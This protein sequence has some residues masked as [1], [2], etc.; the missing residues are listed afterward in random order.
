MRASAP[1]R[2][3]ADLLLEGGYGAHVYVRAAVELINCAPPRLEDLLAALDETV[4][5]DPDARRLVYEPRPAEARLCV[6]VHPELRRWR[7]PDGES[8]A[9]AAV[10]VIAGVRERVDVL[11]PLGIP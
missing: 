4:W 11:T 7:L 5:C 1:P 6:W 9:D 8:L 2:T 3:D 10:E